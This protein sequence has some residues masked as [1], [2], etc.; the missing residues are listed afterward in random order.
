MNY[1]FRIYFDENQVD[2]I[3][4]YDLTIEQ[5]NEIIE[6]YKNFKIEIEVF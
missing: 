4:F 6:S 5:V 1:I 3:Q 2:E